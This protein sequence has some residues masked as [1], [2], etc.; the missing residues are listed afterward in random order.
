MGTRVVV[1]TRRPVGCLPQAWR[2][3]CWIAGNI[4]AS[5]RRE[6]ATAE[7]DR[8]A[9]ENYKGVRRVPSLTFKT[10]DVAELVQFHKHMASQ[11]QILND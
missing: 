10:K 11:L 1:D 3:R 5:D 9:S 7:S 6:L 2:G 4:V 8:G